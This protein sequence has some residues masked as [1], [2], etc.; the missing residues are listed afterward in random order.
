MKLKGCLYHPG[1]YGMSVG[2]GLWKRHTTAQFSIQSHLSPKKWSPGHRQLLP[3]S[4]TMVLS[5]HLSE[6]PPHSIYL[7]FPP[8]PSMLTEG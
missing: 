5:Q 7:V 1:W 8:N 6:D 4:L 3:L 2:Q